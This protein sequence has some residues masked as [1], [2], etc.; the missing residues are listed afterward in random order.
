MAMHQDVNVPTGAPDVDIAAESE[1]GVDMVRL[2]RLVTRDPLLDDVMEAKLQ[3]LML[4]VP[5]EGG[6]FRLRRIQDRQHVADSGAGM[7]GKLG[8]ATNRHAE[9]RRGV[10]F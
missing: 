9:G 6:G 7:L 2:R 10:G 4:A 1:K 5:T 8:E 3:P